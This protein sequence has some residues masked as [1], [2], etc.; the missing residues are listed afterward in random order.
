MK[1]TALQ[2]SLEKSRSPDPNKRIPLPTKAIH[3][4]RK[5]PNG[6]YMHMHKIPG[7]RSVVKYQP[8]NFD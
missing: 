6:S 8:E 3:N 2:L 1:K 4:L 5:L 7:Q